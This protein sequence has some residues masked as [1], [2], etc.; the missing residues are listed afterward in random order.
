MDALVLFGIE[1]TKVI[2][3]LGQHGLSAETKFLQFL[4]GYERSYS[5]LVSSTI[6]TIIII[7]DVGR[8]SMAVD[9]VSSLSLYDIVGFQAKMCGTYYFYVIVIA[10]FIS[11]CLLRCR[12]R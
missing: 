11:L 2:F 5:L 7:L 12:G 10:D 9:N 3:L 8:P 1:I 6:I 4:C